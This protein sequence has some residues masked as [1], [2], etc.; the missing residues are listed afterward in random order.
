[1]RPAFEVQLDGA[2]EK[3]LTPDA[4]PASGNPVCL[5]LKRALILKSGQL[6]VL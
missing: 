5:F 6:V 1:M 3:T 2:N 4:N